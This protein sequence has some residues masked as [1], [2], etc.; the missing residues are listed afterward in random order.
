MS[1]E[2]QKSYLNKDVSINKVNVNILK[3]RVFERKRKEKFQSRVILGSLIISLGL[4]GYF[5]G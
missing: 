2:T 1:I 5:S 4:I 3:N